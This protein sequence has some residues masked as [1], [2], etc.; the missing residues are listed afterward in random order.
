MWGILWNTYFE[1]FIWINCEIDSDFSL[2]FLLIT[3]V[4]LPFLYNTYK[5]AEL[6]FECMYDIRPK[7]IH[8]TKAKPI[9]G[10]RSNRLN[11]DF[12][13]TAAS[14][15]ALMWFWKSSSI[16]GICTVVDKGLQLQTS[17]KFQQSGWECCE[18]LN[19]SV[20]SRTQMFWSDP[21]VPAVD[22]GVLRIEEL[23]PDPRFF[24]SARK[25]MKPTTCRWRLA[26]P[27]AACLQEHGGCRWATRCLCWLKCVQVGTHS[28]IKL[29]HF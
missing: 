21:D 28:Q 1:V 11:S 5:P 23:N 9:T 4:F 22:P 29:H 25:W 16:S 27:P 10:G 2:I 6:S 17:K 3:P 8:L 26:S 13:L 15:P 20:P 24:L 14:W 19:L 7:T 18:S 12:A